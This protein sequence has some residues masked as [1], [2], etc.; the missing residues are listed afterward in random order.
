MRR[1]KM[2]ERGWLR[3]PKNWRVWQLVGELGLIKWEDSPG[4]RL[5]RAP[6]YYSIVRWGASQHKLKRVPLHGS[7]NRKL[8]AVTTCDS[9]R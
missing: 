5:R 8:N 9:A 7:C 1:L 6:S 4:A 2:R 3:E